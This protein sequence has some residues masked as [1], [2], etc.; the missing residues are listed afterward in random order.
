[1]AVKYV[2]VTGG[3]VSGHKYIY[4]PT[5]LLR[6]EMMTPVT[7]TGSAAMFSSCRRSAV[8]VTGSIKKETAMQ[9]GVTDQTGQA[10]VG[11]AEPSLLYNG[12][13]G[14]SMIFFKK[15]SKHFRFA[16]LIYEFWIFIM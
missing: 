16:L 8:S 4:C 15:F 12:F 5:F 6:P 13:S 10:V 14:K 3:V 2:F 1:M 7:N 11:M 9:K